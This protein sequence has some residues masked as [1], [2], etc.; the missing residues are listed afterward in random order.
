VL[1]GSYPENEF[2]ATKG[3]KSAFADSSQIGTSPRRWV[4]FLAGG[5]AGPFGWYRFK[6]YPLLG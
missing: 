3:T 6:M 5:T 2:A 1:T 4:I